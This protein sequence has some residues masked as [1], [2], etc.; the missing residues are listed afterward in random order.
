M[1]NGGNIDYTIRYNV[2][3][4]GL[5]NLKKQLTDISKLS[6][7]QIKI[8]NP[9]LSMAQA[10][11]AMKKVQKAAEEL[12]PALDKSFD[13][14]TGVLNLQKLQESLKSISFQEVQQ[15]LNAIG[16]QGQQALLNISKAALTANVNLKQTSNILDKM[17]QT[18]VNSLKWSVSSS[19]INNFVGVFQQAFGYVQHLDTSLNDIR[20]VTGKSAE[21]MDRFARSA[22]Q[23]AKDLGQSTTAYTEASLIY[24]QQG[25]GDEEVKARAETTL[26]AAN[27]TG[28]TGAQVSEQLTAVWNGY[29]VTAEETEKYVDKLAAV[30]AGT[31]ADLE[32]LSVGMSKVASAAN[33]MGVDIDQLNAQLATIV[34]VTRQAPESAGTALKTIYARM[35]DLK[36]G[37]EDE[38]GIKLGDVSSTLDSIGV[39]VLDASGNLRDLGEV[40][41]EVG[42]KWE[43]WTKAQQ[44]AI[45]QAIA[46]KRQYNNLLALFDNWDMYN[47]SLEM[48][49][50]AEGTLQQ[51]QNV[52]L[53]SVGAHLKTL[54]T[55]WEDLYDSVLDTDSI[56][57]V[58]DKFTE[59]LDK[60][61]KFI[62][63]IGGGKTALLGLAGV[64]TSVFSKQLSQGIF[65]PLLQNMEAVKAN[66]QVL[67]Q[68]TNNINAQAASG[69]IGTAAAKT[70]TE[71]NE[72]FLKYKDL[73]TETQFN[74]GQNI[75]REAGEWADKREEIRKTKQELEE[76]IKLVG[77]QHEQDAIKVGASTYMTPG[78][79]QN[80]TLQDGLAQDQKVLNNINEAFTELIKNVNIYNATKQNSKT[81]TDA[82]QSIQEQ[83]KSLTGMMPKLQKLKDLKL[84]DDKSFDKAQK[85]LENLDKKFQEISKGTKK[86]FTKDDL[87]GI[88]EF[89]NSLNLTDEQLQK[90]VKLL[91]D[92]KAAEEA[93]TE[94][95]EGASQALE[96]D[97][98]ATERKVQAATQLIGQLSQLA[99]VISSASEIGSI[100]A[101]EDLDGLEK[102]QKIASSL[103]FT[104]PMLISAAKGLVTTIGILTGVETKNLTV[105]Q[106]WKAVTDKLKISNLSLKGAITAVTGGLKTLLKALGPIGWAIAGITAAVTVAT[107]AY[108]SY[109]QSLENAAEANK[110]LAES[111][112][113]KLASSKQEQQE[114]DNLAKAYADL[115]AQ[116]EADNQF[117]K[118]Q[119][120]QIYEL[121]RAYGDQDLI[122]KALSGDYDNLE[123][124]IKRAQA[125]ANEDVLRQSQETEGSY[126]L[127]LKSS[128]KSQA[129]MTEDDGEYYDL[130][131]FGLF[132][133]NKDFREEVRQILH[134]DKEVIDEW[135]HITYDNLEKLL[136]TDSTVLEALLSKYENLKAVTQ[137]RKIISDNQDVIQETKT[138]GKATHEA[139]LTDIGYEHQKDIESITN[140]PSYETVLDTLAKEAAA[141]GEEDGRAWAKNFLASY[142]EEFETF[143]QKD[144]IAQA[145]KD[146]IDSI[147]EDGEQVNVDSILER[148]DNVDDSDLSYIAAH[149]DLFGHLIKDGTDLQTILGEVN[150]SLKVVEAKDHVANIDIIL[151]G[152]INTKNK[153]VKEA[154]NNLFTDD[155]IDIGVSPER[156]STMSKSDQY[157]A[158]VQSK[159]QEIAK[160]QSLSQA[161]LAEIEQNNI[162]LDAAIK[163]TD[164]R[165]QELAA[166]KERLEYLTQVEEQDVQ[167][168]LQIQG[169]DTSNLN[170]SE[171]TQEYSEAMSQLRDILNESEGDIAVVMEKYDEVFDQFKNK[172]VLKT[173]FE[174]FNGT[175]DELASYIQN[176][177]SS[178]PELK[179]VSDALQ[180][181]EQH[182][183]ELQQEQKDAVS[184]TI[185]YLQQ[186]ADLKTSIGLLNSDL[187][188]LQ[189]SY[190]ALQGIVEEYNSTGTI[191][192]DNLQQLLTMDDSYVASLQL[193]NGQMSLNEETMQQLAQAKLQQARIEATELY[194]NELSAIA[195]GENVTAAQNMY[196]AEHQYTIA[197]INDVIE[198]CGR[199]INALNGLAL[200]K[201]AALKNSAATKEVTQA[202]YN[203]MQLINSVAA[204]PTSKLLRKNE[205]AKSSASKK[206]AEPKT[207][208]HLE[209]EED[210]LKSINEELNQIE[211]TLSRIQTINDHEWGLDAQKT[212]EEENKLL[213]TQ[214]QKL[215]QKKRLQ[216]TDL[217]T[218]RKQ[219]EYE[220]VVFS[221]DGSSMTNAEGQLNALYAHYNEMVDTY[222]ALSAAEQETY[223]DQLDAEKD[224]I[225]KIENKINDYESKFSDYQSTLDSLLDA[226]YAEIENEIKLFNNMVD[227]HLELDGAE[228]EWND[229]W[230][231]VVQDVQDTDF[232]GQIAKSLGKLNT[233]IGDNINSEVAVL[234]NHL[235]DTVQEV[236]AQI[237]SAN[238]GGEDSL[239][240]DDS[241]ASKQNL[242]NYR[243]KLMDALKS[244]KQEVKSISTIYLKMLDDAQTKINKQIAG[245]NQIG[246]Q[247]EH[248]IALIKLV[249]G[250]KSFEPLERFLDQQYK[251]DLNLINTQRQSQDFWK[252]EI[253]K[254]T[255][256][257]KVTDKNTVQWQTYSD[258]LEKASENYAKAVSDLDKTVEGSLKHLEEWRK[259]Q[260]ASIENVLDKAMSDG[261]GLDTVEE[262]WKLINDYSDKYLDNVERAIE[263]E[264]YT[265][266]LNEAA[267]A[268]GLTAAN[269]EKL[270]RFRDEELKKL[271]EKEKLTSYDIEESKARLEILKQQIAIEDAQKNKSNMRLRR[272]SQGNYSY[273][274]TGD[275]QAIEQAEQGGL[276]AKKAWYELVK[277]RY[278][279]TSDWI[280]DLQKKQSTLLQEIDEAEKNGESERAQVLKELYQRNQEEIVAAFGEAEKNKQDLYQG[281]AQFF[282]QVD[283]AAI[284]P[285]AQTTVRQLVDTWVGGSSQDGFIT[286]VTKAINELESTQEQYAERTSV[287]LTEAGVNYEHLKDNGVDPVK[288]SLEDLVGTNEELSATLDNIND[289]L[290]EQEYNL[291]AIE[292]EYYNLERAAVSAIQS[293]NNAMQVLANTTINTLQQIR[294]AVSAADSAS[295]I[296]PSTASK[297]KTPTSSSNAGTEGAA[298]GPVLFTSHP[299]FVVQTSPYGA[300]G[301]GIYIDNK[302]QV[303]TRSVDETVEW[304]K[305]RDFTRED[306][307]WSIN[308]SIPKFDTGG[309]TGDWGASG[310]IGILHEKELILNKNDTSNILKAVAALRQIVGNST[311]NTNGIEDA[312][313]KSGGAQSQA[314]MQISSGIAQTLASMVTNDNN[315]ISRSMTINADFSGVR[316]AD[317][318]YQALLELQNYGLQQDYSVINNNY[319]P[320]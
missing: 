244:A 140:L 104:L 75:I 243:N 292:T 26:K 94:A 307:N 37:G 258:S 101:D 133:D 150:N 267:K 98:L 108:K 278:K 132:S 257:L 264:S 70:M 263:M 156:F 32:E 287:I 51:Q 77:S 13:T 260:I 200:A 89:Q 149:I 166:S 233:L 81:K 50:N 174:G 312:L 127:A 178:I 33:N 67:D 30:A 11:S 160:I 87:K 294:A 148:L 320:H 119:Q 183:S 283:N 303:M 262:E 122:I 24:Y 247:I 65:T 116:R 46:G 96:L 76:Y 196:N 203:R 12:G 38:N 92:G 277:K 185:N 137:I 298:A 99:F 109:K 73:M 63:L 295:R 302:L 202:Y 186:I 138:A 59:L 40:I 100:I 261:F 315:T 250:E 44:S 4:T 319:A 290:R 195:M 124:S 230:Y 141:A 310:K 279:E 121:V 1:L 221:D 139:T 88:N 20:I 254:Y 165:V 259:N 175:Y 110:S 145:M 225:N 162:Q 171:V 189:S 316:S 164:A 237:A 80:R 235:A 131:G 27:V 62:D 93:Y 58:I 85:A 83:I 266:T 169:I 151:N 231:D 223:K 282:A 213:D 8:D 117:S 215:E 218:R 245:W 179:K 9:S 286:S 220:G 107:A 86:V 5:A 60:I 269:Q 114:I 273:Q 163:E 49:Q 57:G 36:I 147:S 191:S 205:K 23:A 289:Q 19:L 288:D 176:F 146:I 198:A 180:V 246:D 10:L 270:N 115:K 29:K 301:Y 253:A 313:I 181:T 136:T 291:K 72:E 142:S 197:G 21:E 113:E 224:R 74:K 25:L 47:S 318:I 240:G 173:L 201:D 296:T 222:N 28:Q 242:E 42:N 71:L 34:S 314:L 232:G 3:P 135:G 168:Q 212:L 308:K 182:Q 210:I 79:T 172:D 199:G 66:K 45:A 194:M 265:D 90:F 118:A 120:S 2:D 256:L 280:I 227:V 271:N 153:D 35:E 209:R 18:L 293:A 239:F 53:E 159:Q 55:Q 192:L 125:A 158:L 309:Y 248:D 228:K 300:G 304:L 69:E 112:K 187:D 214:L 39:H 204:Q 311:I 217:A 281:T 84:I 91:Q 177:S 276:T 306:G 82:L 134:S 61:T 78:N 154:L 216:E 6:A 157:Y 226:H 274:Y 102:A 188:T 161:E 14:T 207:E 184:T 105:M 103:V 155:T 143:D 15:R 305:K 97:A 219:L 193:Q 190:Q 211:S 41:E 31:A 251:N 208:K 22:N 252:D 317:A 48:S 54:K 68:I 152:D 52:Y 167:G 255:E 17:G 43:G 126:K 272:D 95:I 64:L 285:T 130:S 129:K 284:L 299:K 234:T 268:V 229:F 238:R 106:I 128:I 297:N 249:S 206:A 144:T 56:N 123:E 275:E 7:T 111:Q 170:I 241:A 16:P 236:Q